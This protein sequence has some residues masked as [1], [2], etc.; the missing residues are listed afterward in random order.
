MGGIWNGKH[1]EC[2]RRRLAT[3]EAS[4]DEAVTLRCKPSRVYVVSVLYALYKVS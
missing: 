3:L 4:M 1:D 2:T